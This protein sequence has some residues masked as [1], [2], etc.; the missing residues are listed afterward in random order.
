MGKVPVNLNYTAS[1]EVLAACAGRCGLTNVV[2]SQ[3]L[4]D[5]M[6]VELPVPAVLIEDLAAAPRRSERVAALSLALFAPAWLLRR[7]LRVARRTQ[8]DDLATIIFSSGSTGDPKGVMLSHANIVSNVHQ[9]A[10]TF[11]LGRHDRVMGVLP[12]FHSF[13]FTA[14]LALPARLGIG[15]IYHANPLDAQTIGELV[16]RYAA[17]FLLAT[18]TFLQTY[19]KRCAPDEL[20]SLEYVLA[21]AEKLPE[22]VAQAFEDRFGLRPLEGYGLTE[23]S[24]CVC[25]NTRDFRA[26]GFRQ[27]GAKRGTIGLPLPGVS[28]RVVDPETLAPLGVGAAGMLLVRGPNVMLGYLGDPEK[29]AEVL[30]DGWYVTGDIAAID[31]DGFVQITDRL[32]RFSKIAG[33]MVPH[34]K[35]EDA[36]HE[37]AGSME[38]AFAVAGVPDSKR[39]ERL[40]VLHALSD[41]AL[42]RVVAQL[43]TSGLPNLWL[44]RAEDFHRVES[45]PVLG[46]GKLDLRGVRATALGYAPA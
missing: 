40:V 3:A 44:P 43:P 1:A 31:E 17:T 15:V 37:L 38:R 46:T 7:V 26:R 10:Q 2:T 16:E 22:R 8:P 33:E 19:A 4:L 27:R 18:P 25:V 14:T 21:G 9:F 6:H 11:A 42:A 36:L 41:E 29:T 35:V 30:H 20:G 34:V 28:V 45:F 13:G 5:R 32:S 39:G 23:C 12:F 24:P